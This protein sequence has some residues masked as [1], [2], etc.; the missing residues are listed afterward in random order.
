MRREMEIVSTPRG[1]AVHHRVAVH[2]TPAPS[3]ALERAGAALA[4]VP[5]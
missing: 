5:G 4:P 3:P 2:F 1:G